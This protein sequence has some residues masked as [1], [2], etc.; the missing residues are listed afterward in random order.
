[1]PPS[2]RASAR[3]RDLAMFNLVIKSKLRDCVSL[4]RAGAE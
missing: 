4:R 3:N 1:M 2:A